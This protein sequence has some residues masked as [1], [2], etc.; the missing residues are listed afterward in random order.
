MIERINP[1]H[2]EL[3]KQMVKL[4]MAT[5]AIVLKVWLPQYEL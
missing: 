5:I 3:R 1:L 2:Q 4:S